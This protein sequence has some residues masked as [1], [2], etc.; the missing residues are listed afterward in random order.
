[1]NKYRKLC[2]ELSSGIYCRVSYFTRQYIPED[3]SKHHTRHRENL[4]SQISNIIFTCLYILRMYFQQDKS[5]LTLF[6][7]YSKQ[8]LT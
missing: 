3:N 8:A 6:C 2:S 4:K 5:E 7:I 1:M